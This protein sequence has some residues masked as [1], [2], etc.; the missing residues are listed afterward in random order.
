MQVCAA[1]TSTMIAFIQGDEGEDV[2]LV[3]SLLKHR[4]LLL[5]SPVLSEL[6]SD[7]K[8]DKHVAN[9]LLALPLL[10]ITSGF[11]QRVGSLRA[12]VLATKKK[13]RLADALIAQNCLDHG[14]SLITRDKDFRHFAHHASLNVL[15]NRE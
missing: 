8:L 7:P 1:D 12:C 6:L 2:V 13:A 4:A 9:V 3:Q 14:V 5:P 15:P 10:E 11:W